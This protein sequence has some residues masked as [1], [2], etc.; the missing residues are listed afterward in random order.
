MPVARLQASD[1]RKLWRGSEGVP[2]K[3]DSAPI[4]SLGG[5]FVCGA[6]GNHVSEVEER[7]LVIEE[8]G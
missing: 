6:C 4:P 8:T 2:N 1:V 3:I 7:G 5:F